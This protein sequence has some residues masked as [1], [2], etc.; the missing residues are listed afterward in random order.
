MKKSVVWALAVCLAI[1]LSPRDNGTDRVFAAP[2]LPNDCSGTLTSS[3]LQAI[4][5][6]M[7]FDPENSTSVEWTNCSAVF[8]IDDDYNYETLLDH[9][10]DYGFTPPEDDSD[11]PPEGYED[12]TSAPMES[13]P[14]ESP[15]FGA[16]GRIIAGALSILEYSCPAQTSC[17]KQAIEEVSKWSSCPSGHEC[18]GMSSCYNTTTWC[19]NDPDTDLLCSSSTF[20]Q[21]L[22]NPDSIKFSS[23]K[24]MALVMPSSLSGDGNLGDKM[25]HLCIAN[26]ALSFFKPSEIKAEVKAKHQHNN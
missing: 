17:W 6:Y 14:S 26:R 13:K 15:Q 21:T 25:F 24:S 3:E 1:I 11:D 10:Y 8:D 22:N 23:K 12:P 2:Q 20:S 18:K 4:A 5:W 7:V 19:D 9:M 16:I